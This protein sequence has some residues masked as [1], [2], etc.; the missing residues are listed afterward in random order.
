MTIFFKKSKM[1]VFKKII[2]AT[3]ALCVMFSSVVLTASAEEKTWTMN[4]MFNDATFPKAVQVLP[5]DIPSDQI[6]GFTIDPASLDALPD[7]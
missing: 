6:Y 2:G 7:M 1:S 5:S 3:L 4:E